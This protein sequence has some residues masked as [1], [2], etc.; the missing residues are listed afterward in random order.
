MTFREVEKILE[1]DCWELIRI[2]GSYHQYRKAGNPNSI[3]IANHSGKDLTIGILKNLEK[4][5][6]LSLRR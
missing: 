1:A 6:G 4:K 3:T 5:T 2:S